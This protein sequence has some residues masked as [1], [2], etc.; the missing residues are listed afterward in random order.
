METQS[1]PVP[2]QTTL[3]VQVRYAETD[4]MGV[5]H[6]SVYPVYFEIGRTDLFAHHLIPY[7]VLEKMGVWA[8]VIS[9]SCSLK[10]RAAY[11]NTLLITTIP[12]SLTH[13][14]V[15]FNYEVRQKRTGELVAL[16]DSIHAFIS[17]ERKVLRIK[18]FPELHRLL[19]NIFP[20]PVKEKNTKRN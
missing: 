1:A 12:F 17:P 15:T 7:S 5:V 8:P 6:H 2:F 14:T 16:G 18:N 20:T 9:F 19:T 3:E 11:E 10:S 4:Q 13:T